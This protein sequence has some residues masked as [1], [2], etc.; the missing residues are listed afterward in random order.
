MDRSGIPGTP[1][2][3]TIE[4]FTA[5]IARAADDASDAEAEITAV[6]IEADTKALAPVRG[7][8]RSFREGEPPIGGA[9]RRSYTT[10]KPGQEGNPGGGGDA[11]A[12]V[13]DGGIDVGS[14]LGYSYYVDRGT[15]RMSARPHF[16]TA[17][18]ANLPQRGRR[19][20]QQFERITGGKFK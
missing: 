2:T 13:V 12:N 15:T 11:K 9:L 19:F 5:A 20:A 4:F 10:A 7:A 17:I 6:A 18:A 3:Y 14:W 16:T 8:F 1:M